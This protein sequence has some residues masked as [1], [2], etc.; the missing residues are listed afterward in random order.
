MMQYVDSHTH[1]HTRIHT[2]LNLIELITFYIILS[3]SICQYLSIVSFRTH[4]R[5]S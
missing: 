5:A 2:H 1:T 3:Y 4:F